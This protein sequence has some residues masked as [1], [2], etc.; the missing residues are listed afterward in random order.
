[1][2]RLTLLLVLFAGP[3]QALSCLPPDAVG[4]Y[5]YAR[6]SDSVYSM[7]RGKLYYQREPMRPVPDPTGKDNGVAESPIRLVGMGLGLDGFTVPF[8]RDVTLSLTCLGPWCADIPVTGKEVFVTLRH[9]G[10]RFVI[11]QSAC[12]GNA[13]EATQESEARLITCH[14]TGTCETRY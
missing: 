2:K 8:D 3:V 6:D 5:V 7:V 4:L 11:D 9:D 10:D 14:R 12:N 1:M 13:I